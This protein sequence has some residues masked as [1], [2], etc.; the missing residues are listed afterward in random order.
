[1]KKALRCI[2]DQD[3]INEK[4]IDMI[5]P[6]RSSNESDFF[7]RTPKNAF[8]VKQ[9]M[10]DISKSSIARPTL[11]G[12]SSIMNSIVKSPMNRTG[13]EIAEYNGHL[14]AANLIKSKMPNQISKSA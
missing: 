2:N 5:E 3:L 8:Q 13:Y 14:E 7:V 4:D 10:R 1:M 6:K 9:F 11:I 12:S